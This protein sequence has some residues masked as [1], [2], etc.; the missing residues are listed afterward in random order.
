MSGAAQ[1]I[2]AK[3]LY[4]HQN[5]PT[6]LPYFPNAGFNQ[7]RLNNIGEASSKRQNLTS[8]SYIIDIVTLN[9]IYSFKMR[10][11]CLQWAWSSVPPCK[12]IKV[13]IFFR[14]IEIRNTFQQAITVETLH[15]VRQVNHRKRVLHSH[16]KWWHEA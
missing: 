13:G 10:H 1:A 15:P 3:R 14:R 5:S 6:L 2:F 9:K 16:Q 11:D 12:S 7:L 4:V 8:K